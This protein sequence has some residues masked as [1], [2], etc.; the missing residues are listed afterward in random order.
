[1]SLISPAVAAVAFADVLHSDLET[2]VYGYK[3]TALA[4]SYFV[5]CL[6]LVFQGMICP[7]VK[8]SST[9]RVQKT[10]QGANCRDR[11]SMDNAK[12]KT[13]KQPW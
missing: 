9:H 10:E 5:I 12:P 7:K 2:V 11:V 3:K 8:L 13:E 1:M 4:G 6:T